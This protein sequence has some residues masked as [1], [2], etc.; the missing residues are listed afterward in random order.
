[1]KK[2]LLIGLSVLFLGILF[3]MLGTGRE[4]PGDFSIGGG[5]FIDDVRITQKKGGTTLWTLTA[6]KARFTEDENRAEL[7]DI[8]MELEKNGVVLH[9][10][11]GIYNLSD[12][13]FT[14]DSIVKADAKNYTIT[15]DSVDYEL[16]SGKIST[17]GRITVEGKGF[18]VEGKGM[19]ADSAQRVEI[20]HDVKATFNK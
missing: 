12:R 13:S 3:L 16:S 20:L 9:A 10:E 5:S 2:V 4:T 7:Q 14:T 8:S 1:M 17:D 11:K 6:S 15:A 18:R 19:K